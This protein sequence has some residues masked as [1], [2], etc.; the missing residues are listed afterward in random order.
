MPV[1]VLV[2][3]VLV[4]VLQPTTRALKSHGQMC[5]LPKV[6]SLVMWKKQ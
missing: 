2:V 6:A 4:Y 1:L 5:G 3:L